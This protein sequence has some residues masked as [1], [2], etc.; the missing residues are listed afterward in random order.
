MEPYPKLGHK[1]EYKLL[2][3]LYTYYTNNI[4]IFRGYDLW[5]STELI[6]NETT[7]QYVHAAANLMLIQNESPS[8][9]G[10]FVS[11]GIT[12]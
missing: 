1:C 3:Y 12:C 11:T 10:L 8:D 7:T 4:V 2:R 6:L 5:S 9:S